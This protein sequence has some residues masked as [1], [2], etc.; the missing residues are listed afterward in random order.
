MKA[1]ER[2]DAGQVEVLLKAGASLAAA[3]RVN[4]WTARDWAAKRDDEK[5]RIVAEMLAG[6]PKP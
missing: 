3:D 4:K 2:A 1:A 5:G 6:V